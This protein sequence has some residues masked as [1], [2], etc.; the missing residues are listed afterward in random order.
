MINFDQLMIALLVAG[1]SLDFTTK[2]GRVFQIAGDPRF[3]GFYQRFFHADGHPTRQ[4]IGKDE[5]KLAFAD[6]ASFNLYTS[7]NKGELVSE[8]KLQTM[9]E[10]WFGAK[11]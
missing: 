1:L 3:T 5:C 11:S 4:S 2:D 10:T 7:P 8:E 9:V 6:A